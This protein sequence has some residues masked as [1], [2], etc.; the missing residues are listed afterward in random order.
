M[1]L[2]PFRFP[3]PPL[4]LVHSDQLRRHYSA[5]LYYID[6]SLDD[7]RAYKNSLAE[8]LKNK[9]AEF[10]PLVRG[11]LAGSGILCGAVPC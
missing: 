9:P 10:L 2:N 6:V 11:A 7:L 4:S 1:A 3:G 8:L 5:G